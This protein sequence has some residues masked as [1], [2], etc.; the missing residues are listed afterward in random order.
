[1]MDSVIY[2]GKEIEYTLTQKN[3]KNINLRIHPDGSVYVSANN[4]VPKAEIEEF[5]LSMAD[6]ILKA[7]EHLINTYAAPSELNNN[8]RV[9]LL[10]KKYTLKIMPN[11]KAYY[12]FSEG[13]IILYVKN[14]CDY[15]QR[16]ALFDLLRRD[17]AEKVFKDIVSDCYISFEK[18]CK[19]APRLKIRDMKTQWGNCRCEQNVITLNLKL[20]SYNIETIKFVV[21]H[22]YCHFV[23]PNHSRDFYNLLSDVMPDWKKYDRLLKNKSNYC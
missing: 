9:F 6:R 19:N 2:N 8:D 11:S 4:L 17:L 5:I 13:K 15:G 14:P 21:M 20:I 22:E 1:M 23:H 3:V 16:K 10:G 7:Q 12:A 18:V